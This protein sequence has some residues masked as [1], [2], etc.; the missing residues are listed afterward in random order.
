MIHWSLAVD[1]L[2]TNHASEPR[3]LRL[4]KDLAR[5]ATAD[6]TCPDR[7]LRPCPGNGERPKCERCSGQTM[8][9]VLLLAGPRCPVRTTPLEK[10]AERPEL[11]RATANEP[12]R[13]T[14]TARRPET[15]RRSL[16]YLKGPRGPA[17]HRHSK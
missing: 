5:D 16:H 17:V 14:A 4:L 12:G 7:G 3:R 11:M 8:T 9:S 10:L 1:L 13:F 6:S 2:V 15:S